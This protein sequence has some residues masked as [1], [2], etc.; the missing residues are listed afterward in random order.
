MAAR[1][2]LCAP[3][4]ECDPLVDPECTEAGVKL[5]VPD[6]HGKP[7]RISI[8]APAFRADTSSTEPYSPPNVPPH[9]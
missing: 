9:I 6:S 8:Q 2:Y 3:L 5:R 1:G 7:A 4:V